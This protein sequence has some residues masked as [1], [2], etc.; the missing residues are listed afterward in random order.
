M[1]RE[2]E[3]ENM[4]VT[5]RPFEPDDYPAINDIL[6][7][8][9]PEYPGSVEEMQFNDEHRDP[10][11][12]RQRLVAERDG[13]IVGVAEY[14]QYVSMYHPQRFQVGVEVK[15]DCQGQGIGSLL[16]DHLRAALQP[17]DPLSLRS[18]VRE[19]MVRGVEFLKH[20]GF[21]EDL[22]NWESRLDVAQFDPA[23]FAKAEEQVLAQGIEIKTLR[24]LESDPD[25]N[26]KLYELNW[27]VL[28]DEPSPEPPTKPSY[29]FFLDRLA[30]N[31]NLLPDAYFIAVHGNEYVGL[32]S[33][34]SSQGNQDLYTGDTGVS[35]SYRR[36]GVALALKVRGILYAKAHG[37]PIVKTWNESRNQPILALNGRLGFVRQPAWINFLKVIEAEDK[38]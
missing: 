27:E 30:H 4:N 12:K 29:E 37:H 5:I 32:S 19:D 26:P 22:R 35:R 33:L 36:R 7:A 8:I 20:R 17:F 13:Q 3:E 34:W 28:Q 6:N 38:R 14:N 2:A 31:P 15:P 25:R 21:V 11:C 24:E 10:K 16:F 18:G 1:G 9:Y 23:P